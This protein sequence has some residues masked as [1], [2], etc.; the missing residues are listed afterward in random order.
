MESQKFEKKQLT[1]KEL[2]EL[3]QKMPQDAL[4]WHEG[5]DCFGKADGVVY[6]ESR[7]SVL[8]TRLD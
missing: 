4:V 5:C 2:I 1:V 7:N 8:I 6:R 3:L